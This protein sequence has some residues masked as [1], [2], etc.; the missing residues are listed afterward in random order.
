MVPAQAYRDATVTRMRRALP[1]VLVAL[2]AVACG[3]SGGGPQADGSDPDRSGPS[4][5]VAAAPAAPG[6]APTSS[7][8]GP[9]SKAAGVVQLATRASD[10][11]PVLVDGEGFTLYAQVDPQAPCTGG[12]ASA[13]PALVATRVLAGPG[14]NPTITNPAASASA[15]PAA[16]PSPVVV[17]G[18][19]VHRFAGDLEPGD[20][21]GQGVNRV[22]FM[23]TPDG[24][25]V[26]PPTDR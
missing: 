11:G 14:V 2:V 6:N 7:T 12:C 22:W 24:A 18:R 15:D 25:L 10:Q 19:P 20:A 1:F 21:F 8:I 3:S 5:T 13:W 9:A 23:V 17:A 4:T 16:A 26:V